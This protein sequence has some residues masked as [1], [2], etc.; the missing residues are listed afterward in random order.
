MYNQK[1]QKP[2][3]KSPNSVYFDFDLWWTCRWTHCPQQGEEI[4]F[5]LKQW[6][7]ELRLMSNVHSKKNEWKHINLTPYVVNESEAHNGRDRLSVRRGSRILQGRVSN[8]PE[9]GTGG[10][11]PKAQRGLYGEGP[12]PTPKFF[13]CISCIKMMSFMHSRWYLLTLYNCKPTCF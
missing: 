7:C 9:R 1:K 8:P 6:D 13:F 12:V 5:A 10:Q 11:A 2:N 4:K 3:D